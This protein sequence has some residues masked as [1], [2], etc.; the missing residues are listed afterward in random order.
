MIGA[1][2]ATSASETTVATAA[3]IHAAERTT[4]RASR[5][6]AIP[7]ETARET[8]CSSGRKKTTASRNIPAH[9]APIA[10]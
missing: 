2:A 8:V 9:S 3:P 5:S 4:G 6:R 1:Q 7:S 10:P